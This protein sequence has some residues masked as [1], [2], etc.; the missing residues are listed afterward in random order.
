MNTHCFHLHDSLLLVLST[1]ISS[2]LFVCHGSNPDA[3]RNTGNFSADFSGISPAQLCL[4]LH[5]REEVVLPSPEC[6]VLPL[7]QGCSDNLHPLKCL[8]PS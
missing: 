8:S 6:Q 1:T 5:L 3:A 4:V 2:A 7:S